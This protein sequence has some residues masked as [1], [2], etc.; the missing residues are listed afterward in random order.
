[1]IEERLLTAFGNGSPHRGLIVHDQAAQQI[2][3]V[4]E[5]QRMQRRARPRNDDAR[6]A[7][8]R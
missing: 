2:D 6:I 4:I 8:Q 1:L 7:A 3:A 5:H